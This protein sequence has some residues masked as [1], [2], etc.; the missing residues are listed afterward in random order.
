MKRMALKD[1]LLTILSSSISKDS[2]FLMYVAH[3][4]LL[5]KNKFFFVLEISRTENEFQWSLVCQQHFNPSIPVR[6]SNVV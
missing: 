2:L 5:G 4:K 6:E 1:T 3:T